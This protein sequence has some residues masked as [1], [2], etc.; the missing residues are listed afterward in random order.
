[1]KNAATLF[2]DRGF[3]VTAA[4]SLSASSKQQ[5]ALSACRMKSRESLSL[6]D[7]DPR[8]MMAPCQSMPPVPAYSGAGGAE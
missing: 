5:R 6:R 2:Q 4:D 8:P 1:M 7:P 3:M